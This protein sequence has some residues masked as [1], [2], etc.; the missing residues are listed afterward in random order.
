MTRLVEAQERANEVP[1]LLDKV[2][3]LGRKRGV[4]SAE[5]VW[6]P[7]GILQDLK[8]RQASAAH[9]KHGEPLA[10][11]AEEGRPLKALRQAYVDEL[12]RVGEVLRAVPVLLQADSGV[13]LLLE[14]SEL[15]DA[16]VLHLQT[17]SGSSMV[18]GTE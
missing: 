4:L 8:Q 12:E 3:E 9:R 18:S 13:D 15:I 1:R 6:Q 17:M 14:V 5:D 2:L 16:E 7:L 10:I 11:A